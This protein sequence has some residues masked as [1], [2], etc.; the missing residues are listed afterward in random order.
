MIYLDY[1]ANT[2]V[3]K[4]VLAK[5]DEVTLSCYGNANSLHDSGIYA[6]KLI[7]KASREI[8][9]YFNCE[10]SCVI[11]TSGSSEAN[12]FIIKGVAS[13]HLK[14]KGHII[15]SSNSHSSVIAPCN[16]LTTLGYEVDVIPLNKN[17]VIDLE[18]LENTIQDNTIL[19]S[20]TAVD[21]EIG[22]IQPINDISKLL[23][24]DKNILFHVDATQ[25]IGKVSLDYTGVDFLTFAPHKFY[26]LNGI[27]AAINFNNTKLTPL[28]HGGKSTTIYR[29][30]TPPTASIVAFATALKIALK[31]QEKRY[32]YVLSLNE[33]LISELKNIP[34]I[35]INMPTSSVANIINFSVKNAN[36]VVEKLYKHGIYVSRKSACSNTN[37]PSNSVLAITNDISRAT[38]SIRISISYL[39]T[40]KEL[41]EFIKI[42][43]SV[44]NENN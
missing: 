8:S 22:A 11:Y 16:Y 19:V 3:D 9:S 17:G 27:G 32:N 23:K 35:K 31:N 33:Y 42:L 43:R 10:H 44:A 34:N 4:R 38:N 12:N 14:N 29:S 40:K 36:V 26:G 24:K 20:I 1:A 7:D 21:G 25:A 41:A 15:I 30:G 2:P 5:F 37:S 28:I 39:T 18:K 13:R 6:K